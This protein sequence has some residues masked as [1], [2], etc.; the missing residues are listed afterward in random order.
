VSKSC[1]ECKHWYWDAG[2]PDYSDLT[3]GECWESYCRKK[4]WQANGFKESQV[5]WANKLMT[6]RAC[7]DFELADYA[8]PPTPGAERD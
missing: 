3:P 2:Y 4:H 7:K 6:A 8:T 5:S 1:I